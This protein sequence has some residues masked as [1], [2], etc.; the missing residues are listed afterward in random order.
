MVS[1]RSDVYQMVQLL[2]LRGNREVSRQVR[3]FIIEALRREGVWPPTPELLAELETR[4][5]DEPT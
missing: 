1:F 2:A 3:L 4:L 5:Q